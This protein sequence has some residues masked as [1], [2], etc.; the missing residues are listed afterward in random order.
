MSVIQGLNNLAGATRIGRTSEATQGLK[1]FLPVDDLSGIDFRRART[2]LIS[3]YAQLEELAELANIST[4]FKLDLPDARSSNGLGLD[5]SSLAATL[6]SSEEINASPM[7]FSP[8]GP[9]WDGSSTAELTIGGEYDG[10]NGSGTLEFEVRRAGVHGVDDLRIRVTEP[11]G[12][13]RNYNVR[14]HHDPDR[15]YDLQNGLYFTLGPGALVRR[16]TTSV[17]VFDNVGAVVNPDNPLGGIRNSNPNLQF[18]TPGVVD[19]SFDL[20]GQN[21]N[22]ST[23]DT[24]NDVIDRINLSSAGVTATFNAGT[25]QIDFIQNTTGSVPTIDFANDTS[26]LLQALK[27]S[28]ATVTPGVDPE[29]EQVLDDVAAFSSVVSGDIDINGNLISID[30]SADSLAAILDRINNS[31]ADVIASFDSNTQKVVIEA[32]NAASELIIDS[33]GTGFFGALNIVEG[34][35][36]PEAL[37]S[38]LSRSRSYA[39]ADAATAAFAQLSS[40]FRD[41]TF[42]GRGENTG[43]FRT[44]FESSLRASFGEDIRGELFGLVYDSSTN[45]RRR[46]DYTTIDRQALTQNL[47]LRG[48]AVKDVLINADGTGG[49]VHDLLRATRQ[50]LVGVNQA[51]GL[52][53]TFV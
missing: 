44:P 2:R 53:G 30:T 52:S 42:V 27:L 6:N 15:Q 21:I 45:A 46:G 1:P 17:Q 11:N 4:R 29:D 43:Q 32:Q 38:G 37:S 9:E 48:D 25:E 19:G 18:G 10:A 22:V 14:D 34:R 40:L 35:V 7:S 12:D 26:N 24:I 51:L 31:G 3:L 13:R 20:N 41:S 39:I 8:F 47:Q 50:A 16:E 28:S 23:A 49:L 36:D 5:L 33:N